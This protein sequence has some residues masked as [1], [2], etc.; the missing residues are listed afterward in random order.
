MMAAPIRG[1]SSASG[2]STSFSSRSYG[3]SVTPCIRTLPERFLR[4]TSRK[5]PQLPDLQIA[6][7]PSARHCHPLVLS[8]F[9]RMRA[10]DSAW[11][12]PSPV[13]IYASR[14]VRRVGSFSIVRLRPPPGRRTREGAK[15]VGWVN[16]RMPRA[17]AGRENL[18]AR[19]T[20][21][22]PPHPRAWA[23]AARTNRRLRS[24]NAATNGCSFY[25]SSS[26][27]TRRG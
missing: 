10:S 6:F 13:S 25:R 21:S 3:S 17:R 14:S 26:T 1:Q 8:F 5:I 23:S 20:S 18:V 7:R 22:M 24:S 27:S 2:S 11:I 16:S 9:S 19:W 15:G 4:L 12:S